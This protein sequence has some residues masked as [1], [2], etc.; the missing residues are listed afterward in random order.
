MALSS[1]SPFSHS[2]G[3][4]TTTSQNIDVAWKSNAK[5][6]YPAFGIQCSIMQDGSTI[7]TVGAKFL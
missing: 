2:E 4:G 7:I 1:S 6:F 5:A 3:S